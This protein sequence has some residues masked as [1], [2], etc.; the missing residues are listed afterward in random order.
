MKRYAVIAALALAAS[1]CGSGGSGSQLYARDATSACLTQAGLKVT[2]VTDASDFVAS[3]ATGGAL[4]VRPPDNEVTVS[5]GATLEDATNIE[6]A[7]ER[8]HAH[9]V[10]LSDVLRTQGNAVMLWHLH[11]SDAAL[12]S[13][14]G[15]LKG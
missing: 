8:F 10:G 7:Y 5:F 4:R 14:T 6:Q 9:N 12:A 3:S 1:A 15:C 13:V 2:P 11:P